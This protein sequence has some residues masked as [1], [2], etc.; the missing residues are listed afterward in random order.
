MATKAT[1]TISKNARTGGSKTQHLFCACGQ[2]ISVVSVFRN[3]KLTPEARC[4]TGHMA[5]RPRDLMNG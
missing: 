4:G 1:G 5:R 2:E 3:G